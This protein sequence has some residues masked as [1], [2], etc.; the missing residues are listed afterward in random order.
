MLPRYNILLELAKLHI[1][2]N[3][4]LIDIYMIISSRT[5]EKGKV[6]SIFKK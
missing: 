2:L 1:H 6:E 5:Y 3:T 4:S